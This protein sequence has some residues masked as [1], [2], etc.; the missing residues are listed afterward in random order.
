VPPL[1]ARK[2]DLDLLVDIF[3]R[4]SGEMLQKTM[5]RVSKE[6]LSAFDQYKWP[7]N[8]RELQNTVEFAVNMCE[9]GIV[10]MQNLPLRFREKTESEECIDQDLN[11]KSLEK[12]AIQ[13]ALEKFGT[14]KAGIEQCVKALGLSRATLYRK[15]KSYGIA[16]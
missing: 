5:I 4:K 11:I 12:R 16:L 15:I 6:V 8:V 14:D 10:E 2:D 13:K 7:G 9:T 1:R 3:L